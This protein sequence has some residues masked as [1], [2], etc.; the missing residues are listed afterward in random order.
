MK[1]L[2]VILSCAILLFFT[3]CETLN[4]LPTNTSGSFSL[5]GSWQLS[6][7]TDNRA[8]EGT[9]VA[10]TPGFSTA[11]ART[12]Q[13]NNYCFRDRDVVWKEISSLDSGS[14]SVQNL[15]RACEGTLVYQPG[16]I[17]MITTD[18]VR[19]TSRTAAG[20]ELIQTWR[21]VAPQQ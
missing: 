13:N 4:K 10:V 15:V 17:R 7:S 3:Q 14:F 21:R 20:A 16:S 19:L 6:S 1:G 18:E 11:T 12:I 9:V 5:N 2:S 8:M